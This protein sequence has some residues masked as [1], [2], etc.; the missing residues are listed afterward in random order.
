M[1]SEYDIAVETLWT[2]DLPL[3]QKGEK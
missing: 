1:P 2:L 3:V